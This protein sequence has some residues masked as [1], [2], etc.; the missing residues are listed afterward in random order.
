MASMQIQYQ[1][2]GTE[3]KISHL[4]YVDDLKVIGRNEE[5]LVNEIQIVKTIGNDIKIKFGL[6]KCAK[7]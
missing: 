4:L 7:I 3:R 5:E 1:M 2:Y 6:E